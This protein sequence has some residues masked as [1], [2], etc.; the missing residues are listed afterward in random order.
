L[1]FNDFAS[2]W[3]ENSFVL[4]TTTA[5]PAYLRGLYFDGSANIAF[6][7]NTLPL[8]WTTSGWVRPDDLSARYSFYSKVDSTNGI[9]FRGF[10]D[11]DG[12][13]GVRIG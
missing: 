7:V 11:T 10:V 13:I 6:D 3:T 2:S 9:L 1:Q 4:N 8:T 12:N 5:V